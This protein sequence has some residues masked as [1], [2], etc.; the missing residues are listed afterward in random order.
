MAKVVKENKIGTITDK[1]IS[2]PTK[3]TKLTASAGDAVLLSSPLSFALF[4]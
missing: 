1:N 2:E 3:D 4:Y